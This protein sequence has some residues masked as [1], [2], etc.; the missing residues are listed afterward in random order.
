MKKNIF[1]RIIAIALVAMSIMAIATTAMAES[2][3]YVT[4]PQGAGHTVNIRDSASSTGS[5]LT[6]PTHG[7][8][9]Y[10]TST[11]SGWYGVRYKNPKTG[12]TY[13][14]YMQATYLSNSIPSDTLWIVRYG[15]RDHKQTDSVYTGAGNLQS[16]L[17]TY[18]S[19]HGG[20][21]YSW[22]PL[23]TDGICGANTVKAIKAFQGL[24]GL[25]VDGVAG[26]RTKEYLY[27]ILH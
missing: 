22:Y 26:N 3:K 17:N 4:A 2:T 20:S 24:V 10:I 21:S 23:S 15:T 16:D 8:A 1:T 14:G 6:A 27:K 13:N 7:S 5:I 25:T 9:L 19:T 18:F 11:L 12:I